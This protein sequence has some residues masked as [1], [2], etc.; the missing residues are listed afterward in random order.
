M[1]NWFSYSIT[2]LPCGKYHLESSEYIPRYERRREFYFDGY[3]L[4]QRAYDALVEQPPE[5][6]ITS[7]TS[8]FIKEDNSRHK[9]VL[10][11]EL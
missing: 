2:T 4:C 3:K 11:R 5:I 7:S 10:E 1:Q 8:L 9:M 6:R